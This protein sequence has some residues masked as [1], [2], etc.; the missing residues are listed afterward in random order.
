[1]AH[2]THRCPVG[3]CPAG[4]HPDQLMCPRH[5]RLVPSPL[6]RALHRAW[7]GG[8]GAGSAEHQQAMRACIEAAQA[9]CEPGRDQHAAADGPP[10]PRRLPTPEPHQRRELGRGGRHPLD[11]GDA[12][13]PAQARP[14]HTTLPAVRSRPRQL[15]PWPGDESGRP[16]RTGEA[17]SAPPG[18]YTPGAPPTNRSCQARPVATRGRA[19]Q[20]E[21]SS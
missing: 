7:Q 15:T 8:A 1:M 2:A 12:L 9:S 19:A 14:T 16:P 18:T 5:W 20:R 10:V 11:P 3:D 6:R 21:E 4:V 13:P 17:R